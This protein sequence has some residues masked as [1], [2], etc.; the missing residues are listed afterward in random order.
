MTPG[1]MLA[2]VHEPW[3][4]QRFL[5]NEFASRFSTELTLRFIDAL[6]QWW[7][8]LEHAAAS[9]DPFDVTPGAR[10]QLTRLMAV[11]AV[12]S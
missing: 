12:A 3:A 2:Q 6:G 1:A 5:G 9:L 10:R 8:E 4:A 7:A 11:D